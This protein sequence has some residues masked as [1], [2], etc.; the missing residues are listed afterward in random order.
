MSFQ[1]YQRKT[2]PPWL[3]QPAG[4]AWSDGTAAVKDEL[5][6]DA[7]SAVKARFPEHAPP[8]ALASLGAERG[9]VRGQS[10]TDAQYAARVVSV[11]DRK[12]FAGSPLGLLRELASLGYNGMHLMCVLQGDYSIDGSGNLVI[13]WLS[14]GS[15]TVDAYRSRWNKFQVLF[16]YPHPWVSVGLPASDSAEVNRLRKL[17]KDWAP[18]FATCEGIVVQTSAGMLWGYP[19]DGRYW[20]SNNGSTWGSRCS[21]VTVW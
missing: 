9:V 13:G 16:T 19:D 11:W 6:A 4:L 2:R 10:E 14:V 12:A 20:G 8:D 18:G 1:D 17:V 15:W 7:V 3:L 21:T 5:A